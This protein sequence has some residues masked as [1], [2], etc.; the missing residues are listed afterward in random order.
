[1]VQII[2]HADNKRYFLGLSLMQNQSHSYR[3][4]VT[5][6]KPYDPNSRKWQKNSFWAWGQ[7]GP[8]ISSCIRKKLMIQ[9]W[10][11]LVTWMDR[12]MNR[13]EHP[14]NCYFLLV[15]IWGLQI[16]TEMRMYHSF[17][18]YLI[19]LWSWPIAGSCLFFIVSFPIIY[20]LQNS[21]SEP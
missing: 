3:F 19:C 17:I 6:K 10:E 14:W 4:C 13:V 8:S 18:N 12:Q 9:S 5:A 15:F 11:N 20:S 16:K 2:H 21:G 7:L 1:M